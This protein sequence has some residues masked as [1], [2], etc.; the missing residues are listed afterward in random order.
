MDAFPN[1]IMANARKFYS[2]EWEVWPLMGTLDIVR[3]EES[4]D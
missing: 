4:E 1:F 2:A 3:H